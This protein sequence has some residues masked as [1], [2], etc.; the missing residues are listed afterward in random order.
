MLFGIFQVVAIDEHAPFRRVGVEVRGGVAAGARRDERCELWSGGNPWCGAH[1]L[2]ALRPPR[3]RAAA[4]AFL[5]PSL[6]MAAY[7]LSQSFGLV[8]WAVTG[9]CAF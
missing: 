8:D 3:A 9:G 7:V 2:G 1:W 5:P 6:G 4:R